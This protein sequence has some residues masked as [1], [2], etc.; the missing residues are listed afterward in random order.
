VQ[1]RTLL[2]GNKLDLLPEKRDPQLHVTK[3]EAETFVKSYYG[4]TYHEVSAKDGK[5]AYTLS[6]IILTVAAGTNV[7]QVLNAVAE[8]T[9]L[10]FSRS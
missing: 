5:H 9:H 6:S 3:E 10:T 2:V 7:D 4:V 1:G 8:Q